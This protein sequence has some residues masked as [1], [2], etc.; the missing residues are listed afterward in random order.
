VPG[1]QV[2]PP[3][4][5]IPKAPL[6][7]PVPPAAPWQWFCRHFI[8]ARAT[9]CSLARWP[10]GPCATICAPNSPLPHSPWRSSGGGSHPSF[11]S[12]RSVRCRRLPRYLAHRCH[13]PIDEPQGKLLGQRAHGKFLRHAEN[14]ARGHSVGCYL[15]NAKATT[16]QT[17]VPT[18]YRVRSMPAQLTS[19]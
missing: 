13:H 9:I 10:A 12:R 14:R 6:V 7:R 4:Q 11:R 5:R 3:D 18:H 8:H 15:N 1:P 17:R 2:A 19:R 16:P